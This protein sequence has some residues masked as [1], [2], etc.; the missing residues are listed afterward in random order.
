MSFLKFLPSLSNI[1]ETILL[2]GVIWLVWIQPFNGFFG[3]RLINI[4]LSKVF[5]VR[6]TT[7]LCQFSYRIGLVFHCL[8]KLGNLGRTWGE[9]EGYLVG[10]LKVT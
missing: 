7:H 8:N 1:R 3:Y 10:R 9:L 2:S 4:T 5:W 6:K